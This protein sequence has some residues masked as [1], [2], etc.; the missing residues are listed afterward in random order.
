MKHRRADSN[1]DCLPVQA[2]KRSA[3]TTLGVVAV[4]VSAGDTRSV[5]QTSAVK[6]TER[7]AKKSTPK[8]KRKDT[9]RGAS[10]KEA[11][12]GTRR[13][14]YFWDHNAQLK[15]SLAHSIASGRPQ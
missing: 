5:A 10:K 8:D 1:S 2:H 15:Q 12:G 3:D 11:P 6:E 7:R 14:S 9:K 13:K 4:D